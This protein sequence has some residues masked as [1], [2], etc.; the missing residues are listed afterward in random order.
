[1]AGSG[2]WTWVDIDDIGSQALERVLNLGEYPRAARFTKRLSI[3]P[4]QTHLSREH[5]ALTQAA[6]C[7]RAANNLFGVSESIDRRGVDECD[8]VVDCGLNGSDRFLVIAATPHPSTH[9]P[10]PETDARTLKVSADDS[11]G[12]HIFP[13]T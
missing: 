2:Q 6:G 4:V 12:L 8:T 10:R 5:H 1:V 11:N 9:R 7:E 13:F 3:A